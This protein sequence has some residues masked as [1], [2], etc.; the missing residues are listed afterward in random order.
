MMS[1][2]KHRRL[3][4][5]KKKI[6]DW[7]TMTRFASEMGV[8]RVTVCRWVSGS[9]LPDLDALRKAAKILKCKISDILG[10]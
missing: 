4:C 1:A 5:L 8:S 2:N 9:A 10:E 7:G 6:E 3:D